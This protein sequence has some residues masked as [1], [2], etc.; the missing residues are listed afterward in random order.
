MRWLAHHNTYRF[1][2]YRIGLGLLV[3]GLLAGGVLDAT[4]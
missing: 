3:M 1:V 4:S 2:Y